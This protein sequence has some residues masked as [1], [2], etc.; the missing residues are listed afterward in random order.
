MK[1]T[2]A[3]AFFFEGCPISWHSKLH[4]YITTS[5]NHSEYCAAAKAAKEAK[6]WEK[7]MTERGLTQ[8]VCPIDLFSDSK[9]CIAMTCN[10]V[11]RSASKHVDLAD[12]YARARAARARHHH[13][14]S[15]SSA[16][17]QR[18]DQADALTKHLAC[19][20][21]QRHAAK[22]L[23]PIKQ[24]LTVLLHTSEHVSN[25]NVRIYLNSFP[26]LKYLQYL[27]QLSR[28]QRPFAEKKPRKL[29]KT[30]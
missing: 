14:A 2:L 26:I 15:P 27:L 11:Q 18:H 30:F 5:T 8:F 17:L 9:G 21:F 25:L 16:P 24:S 19:A 28:L 22:L 7:Y 29:R 3:C 23:H 1:S 13:V 6:K 12:H 4:S 20:D 10:P